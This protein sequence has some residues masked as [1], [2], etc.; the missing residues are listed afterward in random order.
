MILASGD[1]VQASVTY[2][3]WSE[4]LSQ[5]NSTFTSLAKVI[6]YD[7]SRENSFQN[8]GQIKF[9]QAKNLLL[10][11]WCLLYLAAYAEGEACSWVSDHV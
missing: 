8:P 5:A 4:I 9:N 7:Q 10:Q 3:N 2:L 6:N 1:I 11:K